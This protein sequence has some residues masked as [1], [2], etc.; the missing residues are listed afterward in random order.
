MQKPQKPENYPL[1]GEE[2]YPLPGEPGYYDPAE[3]YE[4]LAYLMGTDS[5]SDQEREL[6]RLFYAL[7][8]KA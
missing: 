8:P 4:R 1:P 3:D 2:K 7:I 5:E 6:A